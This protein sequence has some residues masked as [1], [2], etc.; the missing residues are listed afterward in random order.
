MMWKEDVREKKNLDGAFLGK[1]F[2][3]DLLQNDTEYPRQKQGCEIEVKIN[4]NKLRHDVGIN[5]SGKS[6]RDLKKKL[7]ERQR[8]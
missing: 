7:S 5:E 1:M 2:H 4:Y 6:Q 3:G 8:K